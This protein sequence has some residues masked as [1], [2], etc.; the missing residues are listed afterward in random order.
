MTEEAKP[1]LGPVQQTTTFDADD[2]PYVLAFD[3]ETIR[4]KEVCD[5]ITY[6][7]YDGEEFEKRTGDAPEDGDYQSGNVKIKST[8][9][10]PATHPATGRIVSASFAF[11][12][13]ET[14]LYNAEVLNWPDTAIDEFEANSYEC[15]LL[16]G[17]GHRITK[18]RITYR[19]PLLSFNGKGFDLMMLRGRCAALGVA[20]KFNWGEV[21]YPWSDANHCDARLL[22]SGK[23]YGKGKLDL[24]AGMMGVECEESGG[25]CQ[26]WY[27]AGEWD[28]FT[29]YGFA[30]MKTLCEMWPR[31][32]RLR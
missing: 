6:H 27:D 19:W 3:F 17:I 15:A 10:F 18:A 4:N 2:G 29:R 21:T 7:E 28:E 12:D 26:G 11:Y 32:A 13:K 14:N 16:E 31:L 1:D 22:L 25:E 30:E 9:T 5:I 23:Q 20:P 24:W 8:G